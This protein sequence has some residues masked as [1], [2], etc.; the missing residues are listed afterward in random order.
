MKY[1]EDGSNNFLRNVGICTKMHDIKAEKHCHF[2]GHCSEEFIVIYLIRFLQAVTRSV[3]VSQTTLRNCRLEVCLFVCLFLARE[4]AVGHG[5][6]IHE[7][8]RS[9]TRKHH[10]R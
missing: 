6:L 10:S 5:L 4:P 8:S 7:I 9:H 2:H 3:S 1:P